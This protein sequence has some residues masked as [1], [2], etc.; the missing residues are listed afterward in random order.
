MD[1]PDASANIPFALVVAFVL[2]ISLTLDCPRGNYY[3]LWCG[4]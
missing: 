2:I 3:D 1:A 4:C